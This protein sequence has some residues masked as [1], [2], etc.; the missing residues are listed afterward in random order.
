MLHGITVL[1]ATQQ[2]WVTFSLYPSKAHTLSLFKHYNV[3]T[4][5]SLNTHTFVRVHYFSFL[6]ALKGAKQ[7]RFIS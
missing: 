5:M 4:S 1:P 3:L 2:Q 7:I 6:L